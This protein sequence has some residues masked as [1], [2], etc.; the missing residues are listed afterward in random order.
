M[1]HLVAALFFVLAFV[2]AGALLHMM[3]RQHRREIVL[4][5]RGQWGAPAV[6]PQV[7]PAR[8]AAP[9]RHAAF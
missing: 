4:A 6:R 7:R 5:L 3:V 9:R 1:N 2:A 8:L